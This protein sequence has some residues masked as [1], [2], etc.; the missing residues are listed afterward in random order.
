MQSLNPLQFASEAIAQIAYYN[1]Q[2][3][4]L[5]TEQKRINEEANIRHHQI[6]AAL[7]A[8]LKLLDE[9]RIA[10]KM[11]LKVVT[12]DLENT[13]I[14]KKQILDSIDNLVKNI[15]D[16]NLSSEEKTL[17]HSTISILSDSLKTMGQESTVKLNLIAQNT[18]K[19]LEAMPRSDL[20]L[21]FSEDE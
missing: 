20:I 15:S 21:T 7:K 18:Q 5:E 13:H 17:S 14:E 8:G 4:I 12:K 2:V 19:A 16:P 9:R 6:D 10:L 11:T 1:H 3:K